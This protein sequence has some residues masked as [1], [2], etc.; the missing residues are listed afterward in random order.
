[1]AK[2]PSIDVLM[3][4]VMSGLVGLDEAVMGLPENLAGLIRIGHKIREL[5]HG[6]PVEFSSAEAACLHEAIDAAT[7]MVLSQRKARISYEKLALQ[8]MEALFVIGDP[9][10]WA[11]RLRAMRD[12]GC[13]VTIVPVLA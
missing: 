13:T 7:G 1:M 8:L 11:F 10:D 12:S 2:Q 5:E 9:A 6:N 3:D 4:A